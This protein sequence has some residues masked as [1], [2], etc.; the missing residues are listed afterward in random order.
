VGRAW[1]GGVFERRMGAKTVPRFRGKSKKGEEKAGRGTKGKGGVARGGVG[2]GA[3][4]NRESPPARKNW[5]L[6]V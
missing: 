3:G 1:V 4:Q 2:R 5:I 6:R